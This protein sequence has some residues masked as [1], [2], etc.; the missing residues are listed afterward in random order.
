MSRGLD[1]SQ[2]S[3]NFPSASTSSADR[4]K[5]EPLMLSSVG[6]MDENITVPAGLNSMMIGPITIPSANSIT[7][8]S[9]GTLTIL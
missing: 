6:S 3:R 9:G 7:I 5:M 1:L 4:L 8:E 2:L